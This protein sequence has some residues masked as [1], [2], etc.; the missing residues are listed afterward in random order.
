MAR[1]ED[2]ITR[3]A[4]ANLETAA[5]IAALP[6]EIRGYGHVKHA[7]VETVRKQWADMLG[8]YQATPVRAEAFATP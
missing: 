6:T 4:P 2:L 5:Q 8:R 1:I 7:N 3:L